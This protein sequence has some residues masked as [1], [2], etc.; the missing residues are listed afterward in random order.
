MEE[1]T[2]FITDHH[3]NQAIQKSSTSSPE[4]N[5]ADAVLEL[6]PRS[7]CSGMPE[8]LN[9]LTFEQV[10]KCPIGRFFVYQEMENADYSRL[11]RVLENF[12]N[13]KHRSLENVERTF[14]VVSTLIHAE[15]FE[16]VCSMMREKLEDLKSRYQKEAGTDLSLVR[17]RR[18]SLEAKSPQLRNA[19]T[20]SLFTE[21]D[22]DQK[23]LCLYLEDIF[24][25]EYKM[26][27]HPLVDALYSVMKPFFE[28]F[29]S[30]ELA[31]SKYR[32]V[33][34]YAYSK[35]IGM[36]DFVI[37]RDLGRGAFGVVSGARHR[38]T[39]QMVA[40]KGMN[41]KLVKGKRVL[42]LVQGEFEILKKL[43]EYP[44]PFCVS[45]SYAFMTSSDMYF[46]LPLCTGGDLL[47][48]IHSQGS[49]YGIERAKFFAAE[50]LVGIQH[51]HN[52]GIIYRDLKP[53]NVLLT[54]KGHTKISDMG[55][56][57]LCSFNPFTRR[58]KQL[59]G[60]AGTPGYW[61]PE[62]IKGDG[63]A[64]DCDYWS[65]GTMLYELIVGVCPF[66]ESHSKCK[67]RN[68]AT[69][70]YVL[71]F[72]ELGDSTPFPEHAQSLIESLLNRD[73][74]KRL[75]IQPYT[76]ELL[77]CHPFFNGI[78]WALL[79]TGNCTTPWAPPSN[80]INAFSQSALETRNKESDFKNVVLSEEDTIADFS[81]KARE[82]YDDI[83]TILKL[84][85]SGKLQHLKSKQNSVACVIL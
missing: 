24:A 20:S 68:D 13:L 3:Y 40:L 45:L 7:K 76:P 55:L 11:F 84:E 50:V 1:I 32:D 46:G 19:E 22:A 12:E 18:K 64:F 66:S 27:F 49:G 70:N 34:L 57:V 23:Y 33:Y 30:N 83:A 62:M 75:G 81:F 80:A 36:A 10:I 67:D 60:R 6:W 54:E 74:S 72:P 39:G 56:A 48:H 41:R 65:F 35:P 31:L 8:F 9:Q 16:S 59:K 37:F 73:R 52:L 85:K 79:E 14:Q 77:K 47:Y 69:L 82:H 26:F 42:K 21:E 4:D 43:G 2:E 15:P 53:E 28:S 63:Y 78:D 61:P 29:K 51:M 44:S 5:T 58:K 38:V 25:R 71:Q 17:M